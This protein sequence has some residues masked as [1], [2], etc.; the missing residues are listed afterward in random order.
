MRTGVWTVPMLVPPL[1]LKH[2]FILPPPA[3]SNLIG[4]AAYRH[5]LTSFVTTPTNRSQDIVIST[6]LSTT[7]IFTL[8]T[9]ICYNLCRVPDN[10][11]TLALTIGIASSSSTIKFKLSDILRISTRPECS[12]TLLATL[13]Y[14]E[15]RLPLDL[16]LFPP[17]CNCSNR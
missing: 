8:P 2:H 15:Y 7:F 1:L 3:K 6:L 16:H 10:W 17:T 5:S 4:S 9:T 11:S 12:L 13:S 14:V